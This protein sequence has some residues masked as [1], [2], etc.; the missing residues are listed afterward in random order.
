[1]KNDLTVIERQELFG[2]EVAIY[3]TLQNPLFLAKEIGRWLNIKNTTQLINRLDESEVTM[4]NIGSRSG[5]TWFVT[6]DGLYE[7]LMQSRKP[8]AKEFKKGI[9]RILKEIRTKG[10]YIAE[11]PDDTP[12]DIM[13]RALKVADATLKRRE[14]R[15]RELESHNSELTVVTTK[16][17]EYIARITPAA[18]YA[19][20]VLL[21]ND[22]YTSTQMAKELGLTSA[23][24]LHKELHKKGVMFRQS[25]SWML[26]A[27]YSTKGYTKA[28][29]FTYVKGVGEVGTKTIT[30]WTETGRVFLNK[31][32]NRYKSTAL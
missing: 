11:R 17:Q 4:L 5:D 29:T 1:M 10:G 27:D 30:V 7:I 3:G 20:E 15:I 23:V 9:K 26:T 18:N 2:K 24:A 28:R 21:S 12:E 14:E 25:N 13:A 6:E 16:Q 8:I 19:E 32:F 31:M 22:A